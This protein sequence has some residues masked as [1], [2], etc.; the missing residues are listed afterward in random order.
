MGDRYRYTGGR[1]TRADGETVQQGDVFKPTEREKEKVGDLLE[2]VTE[3]APV[4]GAD[5]GLRSLPMTDTALEEALEAGLEV[6]DFDGI[7]PAG[8]NGDYLVSQVRDLTGE[9]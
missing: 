5:I 4:Q 7:E 8:S 1:H 9:E 6:S 3:S 2:P